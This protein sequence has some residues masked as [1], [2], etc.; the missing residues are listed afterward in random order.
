MES[1]K[2]ALEGI[3]QIDFSADTGEG[4]ERLA[5][6]LKKGVTQ[7]LGPLGRREIHK[8][9]LR[10]RRSLQEKMSENERAHE[11]A[12]GTDKMAKPPHPTMALEEFQQLTEEL[13]PGAYS[14]NPEA[15]LRLLHR[16]GFLFYDGEHMKDSVVLDQR[17]AINGIYTALN[18]ET[19]WPHLEA[20]GGRCT[21][22]QLREW[23][24]TKAGFSPEQMG[25]FLHF[26][27]SCGL[28]YKFG[29]N[30][31]EQEQYVIVKA[32]PRYGVNL[33]QEANDYRGDLK[34]FDTR[35][36]ENDV[37]SGDAVLQL[38][39]SLGS[40]W[41]R[42]GVIWEW[43]GQFQSHRKGWEEA[44]QETYVHM[45]WVPKIKGSF[46]GA[47]TLTQYGPD[48]SFLQ[49]IINECRAL[50]GFRSVELPVFED[51]ELPGSGDELGGRA[52]D[53]GSH[54]PD[55]AYSNTVVVAVSF[56]GD[57]SGQ[58]KNLSELPADSIERWPMTLIRRLRREK[59]L[60]DDYRS[61]QARPE[62]LQER[63]RLTYL[64]KLVGAD[65]VFCVLSESYLES[66]WC[67]WEFMNVVNRNQTE[68]TGRVGFCSS[69][70]V[71]LPGGSFSQ[72]AALHGGGGEE[73][74]S[75]GSFRKHWNRASDSFNDV[76][77]EEYQEVRNKSATG[78]E[79]I[80]NA[81]AYKDWMTCVANDGCMGDVIAALKGNGFSIKRLNSLEPI[82][83]A[84]DE[85]LSTLIENVGRREMLLNLARKT[86]PSDRNRSKRLLIRAI[87]SGDPDGQPD[88]LG[89]VLKRS[90]GDDVLD[91]I[92]SAVERN[93]SAALEE[94]KE[95]SCWRELEKISAPESADIRSQ[96]KSK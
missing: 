16:S 26:M 37:L 56:A 51:Q 31:L 19:A 23:G 82:P 24:W 78:R 59:F 4:K 20:A 34:V 79:P 46:G 53:I 57:Q 3:E 96:G 92:Q 81:Y 14:K 86:W 7:V 29:K 77:E 48:E 6:W 10:V 54:I 45:N 71:A 38:V 1:N 25:L 74:K 67:M 17:W 90:L 40:R 15:L 47:L 65:Y 41:R 43:G 75:A 28:A 63:D 8:N 30:R 18:R 35:I 64:K 39:C 72:T 22:E 88:G 91:D 32:L 83:D 12:E 84:L 60:V 87:F 52:A 13:C 2:E 21:L 58:V 44:P 36:L 62:Y 85:M 94:G 68:L 89:V 66:P 69:R 61:E 55:E 95:V 80:T 73:R 49:A 93:Y 76:V 42:A 33:M 11:A 5:E 70:L 27:E 9:A 50:A